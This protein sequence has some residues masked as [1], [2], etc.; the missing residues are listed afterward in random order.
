M[1]WGLKPHLPY[2]GC[3]IAKAPTWLLQKLLTHPG[4]HHAG[5]HAVEHAAALAEVTTRYGAG[6][7]RQADLQGDGHYD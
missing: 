6:E 3:P 5:D 7:G 1:P 4:M 2:G